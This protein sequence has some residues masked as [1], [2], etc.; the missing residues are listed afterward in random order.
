MRPFFQNYLA[1]FV[2]LVIAIVLMILT[3]WIGLAYT[4]LTFLFRL[5]LLDL[6]RGLNKLLLKMAVSIDQ[7]GNVVMQEL[8]NVIIIKK[9]S[10]DK[11]GNEDETISS[12][13]GKNQLTNSLTKFGKFL[14]NILNAL[15]RNHS[16][17]SIESGRSV[18]M[19]V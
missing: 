17:N 10:V 1:G 5:R 15:D 2:L 6:L 19:K 3:G 4:I 16:L 11:F 8:F 12:V 9:T 13:I 14:N 7:L 18:G